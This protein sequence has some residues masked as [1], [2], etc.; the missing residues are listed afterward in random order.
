M[1]ESTADVVIRDG[2]VVIFNYVLRSDEG[3]VLD[4][5]EAD[6]PMAYL[7]GADN[8]VPG[9]ESQ[10]SGRRVGDRFDAIVPPS[11]GYGVRDESAIRVIP[12]EAFPEDA[13]LAPG[14]EL[15]VEDDEGDLTPIWIA[16]LRDDVVIVD[17]NHP[18]ADQTLCF[19][20]EIIGIRDATESEIEH[21]HPHGVDGEE[22]D[23][24][25]EDE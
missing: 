5:S 12:R 20:V 16:E 9:L 11:E 21:G 1:L 17:L 22:L 15:V 14:M 25:D 6:D 2:K 8:I 10:M 24:D 3:E 13:D 7:H 4:E 18:L 19:T 23:E